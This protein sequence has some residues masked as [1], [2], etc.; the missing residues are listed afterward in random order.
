MNRGL[1]K[2]FDSMLKRKASR[3]FG[4]ADL[5]AVPPGR[6]QVLDVDRDAS[7]RDFVEENGLN[8]KPAATA[9]RLLICV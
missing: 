4:E 8:F 3:E 1:N 2:I 7:I 9:F 5:H 6:F